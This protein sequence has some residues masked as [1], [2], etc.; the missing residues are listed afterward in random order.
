MLLSSGSDFRPPIVSRASGSAETASGVHPHLVDFDNILDT[1]SPATQRGTSN[2]GRSLCCHFARNGPSSQLHAGAVRERDGQANSDG[3]CRS[4]ECIDNV[5]HVGGRRP[6][7]PS[8]GSPSQVRNATTGVVQAADYIE[9]AVWRNRTILQRA[10]G[11]H[12][13]KNVNYILLCGVIFSG[14][15]RHDFTLVILFQWASLN[16]CSRFDFALN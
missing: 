7:R 5:E 10:R 16:P 14:V 12:P 9:R 6:L 2:E 4:S 15:G 3:E 11:E 8:S 1:S 13:L